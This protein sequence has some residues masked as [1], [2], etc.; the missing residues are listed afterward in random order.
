M[1]YKLKYSL[2]LD[3]FETKLNVDD[4]FNQQASVDIGFLGVTI[5]HVT[6]QC[7]QYSCNVTH[8]CNQTKGVNIHVL[9]L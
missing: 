4:V 9:R 8:T 6:L 3:C 7:S 2:D 1:K 5:S